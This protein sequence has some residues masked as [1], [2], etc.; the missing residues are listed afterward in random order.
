MRTAGRRSSADHMMR[1]SNGAG[2]GIE[3][4][5]N[6]GA[7]SA[8]MGVGMPKRESERLSGNKGAEWCE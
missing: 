3:D 5:Q 1:S 6:V 2:N 8:Q 4:A 7:N